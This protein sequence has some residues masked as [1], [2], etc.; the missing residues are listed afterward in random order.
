LPWGMQCQVVRSTVPR[1]LNLRRRLC[2]TTWRRI[3]MKLDV[4][5][6]PQFLDAE[7][8]AGCLCAVVDVLRA[9]TTIVTSLV[10]GATAVYPCLTSDEAKRRA[11]GHNGPC[12]LGG[13]ERG[14]LI[15]G[16]DLGNSPLEYSTDVVGDKGIYFYTTNGSGAIRRAHD[17]TGRPVCVAAMANASAVASHVLNTLTRRQAD[18][19]V[20]LCSGRFGKPSAEDT[21]CAGVIL[22]TIYDG[23]RA[24][25]IETDAGDTAAIAMGY[26]VANRGRAEEVVATSDHGRFLLSLGFAADLGF[27]SRK[28]TH[29]VVPVFDGDHIALIA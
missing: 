2:Y 26:T 24:A 1:V 12:L 20:I 14:M 16:F 3:A 7:E 27:C 11:A 23:L 6:T 29:D 28:D 19:A 9:P 17:A 8:L 18:G 22:Q 15:E 13:E 4:L 5:V 21:F 10:N 25:G